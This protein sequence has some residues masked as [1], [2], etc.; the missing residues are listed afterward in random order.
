MGVNTRANIPTNIV[1]EL[2][3][4]VKAGAIESMEV[5]NPLAVVLKAIAIPQK[6]LKVIKGFS[7]SAAYPIIINKIHVTTP[8]KIYKNYFSSFYKL[9]KTLRNLYSHGRRDYFPLL[10]SIHPNTP[11]K[12]KHNFHKRRNSSENTILKLVLLFKIKEHFKNYF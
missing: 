1:E 2:I 7:Q 11:S 6:R 4:P 10:H 9:T 8:A 12:L 3:S 5:K